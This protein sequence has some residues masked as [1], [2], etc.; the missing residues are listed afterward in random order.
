[1][2]IESFLKP[3]ALTGELV[4]KGCDNQMQIQRWGR[5]IA[6]AGTPHAASGGTALAYVTLML[7]G[8]AASSYSFAEADVDDLLNETISLKFRQV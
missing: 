2:P 7:T 4:A 8:F 5:V 3:G 6:Q 1:M